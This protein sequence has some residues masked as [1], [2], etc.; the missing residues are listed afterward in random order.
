MIQGNPEKSLINPNS[1]VITEGMAEK[2]F[3]EGRY[4]GFNMFLTDWRSDKLPRDHQERQRCVQQA[5]DD[6]ELEVYEAGDGRKALRVVQ[7]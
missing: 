4:V 2:Y 6:G 5:I 3:G 1:A 7:D